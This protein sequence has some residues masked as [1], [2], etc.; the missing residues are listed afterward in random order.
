[1]KY[2]L[3]YFAVLDALRAKNPSYWLCCKNK[4]CGLFKNTLLAKRLF[5]SGLEMKNAYLSYFA[6]DDIVSATRLINVA[7]KLCHQYHYD[8]LFFALLPEEYV[9]L[10]N[11]LANYARCQISNATVYGTEALQNRLISIN[12]AE[13]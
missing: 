13:I 7:L 9:M 10:K 4:A 2:N 5:L 3:R 12:S 1:M 6:F 8:G 11:S